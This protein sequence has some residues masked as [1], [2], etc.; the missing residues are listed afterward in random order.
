MKKRGS[1]LPG[2]AGRAGLAFLG[3]CLLV[4][5][6]VSAGSAPSPPDAL[7]ISG[8]DRLAIPPLPESPTP[9][10][11]GRRLYYFHCMPCHGDRGQGLTD[12]WRQVW[13]E[14][15]RNCWGRGCHA[16]RSDLDA[17][18][19]PHSVPPVIGSPSALHAFPTAGD[20][21]AFLEEEH[22]PQRPG[23]LSEA[24]NWALTAFLW[25]EN[26]RPLPDRLAGSQAGQGRAAGSDLLLATLLPL[27]A[28][29]L[30]RRQKSSGR[31]RCKSN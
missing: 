22:P 19:L 4:T 15:H 26:G 30:V 10:D 2:R 17:F 20:L 23:A 29:L 9:V 18:Y 6:Q 25:Q 3:L 16:G 31:T 8:L 11:R 12:E 7:P 14:D 27:L 24:E 1:L 5:G 13:V 28:L 21:F